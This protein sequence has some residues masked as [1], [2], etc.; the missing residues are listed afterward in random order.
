[1]NWNEGSSYAGRPGRAVPRK[2]DAAV[3]KVAA[4][5]K[6]FGFRQPIVVDE[7]MVV[8]AGHTRLLAAR[9]LG[10]AKVPVHI[11]E[12]LTDTQA[13][14]YRLADNRTGQDAEWDM[15][16][17]GLEMRDLDYVEFDLSLIGFNDDELGDLFDGVPTSGSTEVRGSLADRFG[18]VPF[19]VLNAREGWWQ[20]RKREWL[21]LGIQS[22]LGRGGGHLE[23]VQDRQP[24][25]PP[26]GI[27]CAVTEGVG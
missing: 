12:G 9:Q 8:I 21:S 3:A 1:V 24:G 16:L 23:G 17:L 13:K 7:A 19:S 22:E 26:T 2:N 15:D 14:A 6:E 20:D 27:Q 25:R 5:I 18:A 10:L 4:S 11:A